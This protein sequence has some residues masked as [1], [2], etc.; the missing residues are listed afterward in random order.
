MIRSVVV[1]NFFFFLFS[2]SFHLDFFNHAHEGRSLAGDTPI[3]HRAKNF[4][5]LMRRS[6]GGYRI[7]DIGVISLLFSII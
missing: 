7:S 4:N 6:G 1:V 5:V 3:F 2:F